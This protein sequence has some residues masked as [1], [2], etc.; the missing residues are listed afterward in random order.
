MLLLCAASSLS[1]EA[2]SDL[3]RTSVQSWGLAD[4]L[5]EESIADIEESPD[6]F[7]WLATREGLVRFD[8][9]SFRNFHPAEGARL[10]DSALGAIAA[11]KN[12]LWA[13]G[14]D[15]FS[16]A[17]PDQFQSFSKLNFQ[18]VPFPR[19]NGDRYG[20]ASIAIQADGSALMWRSEGV[21]RLKPESQAPPMIFLAPPVGEKILGFHKG[22]SGRYWIVTHTGLKLWEAS[23]WKPVS[24]TPNRT[25]NLLEARDGTLWVYTQ[26][27]LYHAGSAALKRYDIRAGMVV[28]A[29][30]GLMEDRSGAIW[31]GSF[32]SVARVSGGHLEWM[33]L[34]DHL[35]PDDL[36]Q[37]LHQSQDGGIWMGSRLGVLIRVEERVFSSIDH[38]QGLEASSIAALQQDR[39]GRIWIG[40]RTRGAFVEK[41]NRWHR[42]PGTEGTVLLTMA[43]LR[44]GR[45]LGADARGVWLG[46]RR[47][48]KVI[49]HSPDH[50]PGP[51]RAFSPDYGG[52]IYFNDAA[53]IY[54][55][56]LSSLGNPRKVADLPAVR[57]ILEAE[58]GLWAMSWDRGLAHIANGNVTE[59]PLDP[60]RS[61]RGLA[62][63]ELS[64]KLFLI[65]TSTG[66]FAFD[67]VA[68]QFVARHPI[69][70]GDQIFFIQP[71]NE[72]NLWFAGR[73]ALLT[74]SR[75]AVTAY[76]EGR[77][78]PILPTRL[79]AKQGLVSTNFG[80]GTTATGILSRAGDIWLASQ[81]G[82]IRFRPSAVIS[83]NTQ[84][85]CAVEEVTADGASVPLASTVRLEPGTHRVQI[86]Y[87]V[88]GRKAAENPVFRYRMHGEDDPWVESNAFQ[89][90]YTNLRPG[91]YTFQVQARVAAAGWS[92]KIASLDL[93]VEPLWS[94]RA[95]VRWGAALALVVL[96]VGGIRVR[97]RRI[98]RQT[99]ILENKVRARTAELAL[100]RDEAERSKQ[101]AEAAARVKSEFLAN[102]SHEI[103]TP[104]NGVIGMTELALQTELTPSQRDYLSLAKLSADSLLTV[105]N[106]VLDFSKIEAGK[107]NLDPAPF[108]LRQVIEDSVRMVAVSAQ[109]KG[110]ALSWQVSEEAPE[111]VLGDSARLRQVLLNLLSNAVKFTQQGA[112]SVSVVLET[113]S[114]FHFTVR[115]TGI[116]IP[117]ENQ[118]R[119]FQAFEQA[120][121]STTRRH[122]GTGL[123]L[124]IASRLVR[125][126]DGRLWLE[127]EPGKGATFHFTACLGRAACL[128]DQL[129][130]RES[131]PLPVGKPARQYRILLAEDNP[132]NQRVAVQL[133]VSRGYDVTLVCNGLEVLAALKKHSFDLLLLDVQMPEMDGLEATREIRRRQ[134]GSARIPIVAL[135]AGAFQEDRE[136]CLA[137]GMDDYIT[138]PIISSDLFARLE[139]WLTPQP[140]EALR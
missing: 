9:Q 108:A 92:D 40:S 39:D 120:D 11:G 122:G 26:D 126:M 54:R 47:G 139:R 137:A 100:A 73:R 68:R 7:I 5:G 20:I 46:D 121:S 31:V 113:E 51:F 130:R 138:K 27:I 16:F 12:V 101:T 103:R 125:M 95:D 116:G 84:V 56:S 48:V 55:L 65:G 96:I 115:D 52:Y 38:R 66:V 102:M 93:I 112:I 61:R 71:D 15:Y 43:A 82:A 78:S 77:G 140:E 62:L 2:P 24:D 89:A 94:Q 21:Y 1:A 81:G 129:I 99:D 3:L 90:I 58:D 136:K 104:I 88:L 34:K 49:Q 135:T 91:K 97:L 60:S 107:M 72:G 69:F 74:A 14:R 10:H 132:I 114:L 8:G 70:T 105:I 127:S 25:A 118:S 37:T 63:F 44:D 133:L 28:G 29:V 59:Y 134:N 111:T 53:G 86:Q 13:G 79:T 45:M 67:R 6:G 76:F 98:R 117:P 41:G 128:P 124:A 36:V 33:A 57:S 22:R 131:Q 35:R 19:Q 64:P 80:L 23:S 106:E 87:T 42:V 110:I 30:R 109:Q 4:G 123:G 83:A 32:G 18:A 50:S 119:I 17:R 85:P 75:E